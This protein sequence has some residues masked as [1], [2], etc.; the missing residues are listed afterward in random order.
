M[1]DSLTQSI[2][3][4]SIY[5]THIDI[6][7]CTT[8]TSN[9]TYLQ[10]FPFLTCIFLVHDYMTTTVRFTVD[11]TGVRILLVDDSLTILHGTE[12]SLKTKVIVNV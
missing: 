10:S 5:L 2:Q 4:L 3:L 9:T 7:L 12:R 8:C 6:E 1:I 11:G